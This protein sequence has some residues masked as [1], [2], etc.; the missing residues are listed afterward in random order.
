MFD[1][2]LG[3]SKV[4]RR[5]KVSRTFLGAVSCSQDMNISECSRKRKD[6]IL[7]GAV[8]IRKTYSAWPPGM[9]ISMAPR[10]TPAEELPSVIIRR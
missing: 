3:S 10:K 1:Q 5:S 4:C 2:L 9:G 8:N 7:T 6:D